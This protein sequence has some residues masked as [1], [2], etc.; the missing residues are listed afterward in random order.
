MFK[1]YSYQ[2]LLI[3]FSSCPV[4]IFT[5]FSIYKYKKNNYERKFI[6]FF[7]I[8]TFIF[9]MF[10]KYFWLYKMNNLYIANIYIPI[11]FF[12]LLSLYQFN[13][14]EIINKFYFYIILSLFFTFYVINIFYFQGFFSDYSS[15]AK[16]LESVIFIILSQVYFYKILIHLDVEFLLRE[17]MF[18]INTGVLIYFSADIFIFIFGNYLMK[19]S[20]NLN[21]QMW[22]I[23]AVFLMIFYTLLSVS[24]CVTPAPKISN[25]DG[26]Y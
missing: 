3:L 4:I 16:T 14:H 6:L 12:I 21:I 17:P 7:F 26:F 1:D 15:N 2:Q 20:E 9:D 23:H 22:A 19:Y 5:I 11:E 24:L 25:S 18:W 8:N 13:L 10:L